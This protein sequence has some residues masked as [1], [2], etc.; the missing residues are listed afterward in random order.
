MD[1]SGTVLK[2]RMACLKKHGA[3]YDDRGNCS[4]REIANEGKILERSQGEIIALVI[5]D[6][7]STPQRQEIY[8]HALAEE[9]VRQNWNEVWFETWDMYL[10]QS[11]G[12]GKNKGGKG[13]KG[14]DGRSEYEEALNS[15]RAIRNQNWEK[16][17]SEWEKNN[18]REKGFGKGQT[19]GKQ[20]TDFVYI[21]TTIPGHKT[22]TSLSRTGI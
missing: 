7:A 18:L 11:K 16:R 4:L 12:K 8:I 5:T 3:V 21:R 6:Y 14:D 17:V 15:E 10:L 1:G 20:C 9:V 22:Q 13:G 19:K 2:A